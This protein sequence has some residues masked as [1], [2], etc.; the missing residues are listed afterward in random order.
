MMVL[1]HPRRVQSRF[2]LFIQK[3][4]PHTRLKV[5]IYHRTPLSLYPGTDLHLVFDLAAKVE[6]DTPVVIGTT[7]PRHAWQ[8]TYRVSANLRHVP[9][10][11]HRFLTALATHGG[12]VL[13][14]DDAPSSAR[15]PDSHEF[16]ALVDFSLLHA[17]LRSVRSSLPEDLTEVAA[18]LLM[19]VCFD[20]LSPVPDERS[21]LLGRRR[22]IS[23]NKRSS[24]KIRP[25]RCLQRVHALALN[26]EVIRTKVTADGSVALP[27]SWLEKL[28][29]DVESYVVTTDTKERVLRF[30][31]L[32]RDQPDRWCAIRYRSQKDSLPNLT[33]NIRS[34]GLN[35]VTALSRPELTDSSHWFEVL[36]SPTDS[37]PDP[38]NTGDIAGEIRS[39]V[40]EADPS[41]DVYFNFDAARNARKRETPPPAP[42]ARK[43]VT[44]DEWINSTEAL[45]H[46]LDVHISESDHR[47]VR[48]AVHAIKF[49]TGRGRPRVFISVAYDGNHD[50]IREI[51]RACSE[52][53]CEP[54][55]ARI[56]RDP[57]VREGVI[58]EIRD[59]ECFLG[60]WTMHRRT[61]KQ[62]DIAPS[63]WCVWEAGV[64]EAFNIE[65]HFVLESSINRSYY[66]A[67]YADKPC[68]SFQR[69]SMDSFRD[70]IMTKVQQFRDIKRSYSRRA[71][72]D[73]L[74]EYGEDDDPC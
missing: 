38:G 11:M 70:A 65:T 61:T 64:A 56:T 72:G 63:P 8:H 21:R 46:G 22:E 68:L 10:A 53:E 16:E 25:A 23:Q 19:G 41:A 32:L 71:F 66:E 17:E 62:E 49:L 67:I 59:S 37:K 47:D 33:R 29:T 35:I 31:F 44:I 1:D 58:R 4:L 36:V 24:V 2:P 18:A 51:E 48:S 9:G 28:H 30:N 27:R 3:R 54:H 26:T 5:P 73:D 12:H 40:H 39:A 55:I 20:V 50:L 69:R 34:H 42:S 52:V 60:V 14:F 6:D 7:V 45:L 13:L 15:E 74:S 57:T 43:V